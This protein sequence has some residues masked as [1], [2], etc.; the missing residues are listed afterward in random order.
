MTISMYN[1]KSRMECERRNTLNQISIQDKGK[2]YHLSVLAKKA[3]IENNSTMEFLEENMEPGIFYMEQEKVIA[4]KE[5]QIKIKRYLKYLEEAIILD[6]NIDAQMKICGKFVKSHIDLLVF[7]PGL[8]ILEAVNIKLNKPKLS[9]RGRKFSTKPANDVE[10]YSLYNSLLHLDLNYYFSKAYPLK[11]Q[12]EI[13]LMVDKT[14]AV[15]SLHHLTSKKDKKGQLAESYNEKKGDNVIAS[16]TF[17]EELENMLKDIINTQSSF[18]RMENENCE[19]CTYQS[20]CVLESKSQIELEEIKETKIK[21]NNNFNLTKAQ[22]KAINFNN[23]IARINAGAGSGKTTIVSLRVVELIKKGVKP[24]DILLITFTNKGALEM[25]E[26]ISYWLKK[27]DLT[28]VNIDELDIMTFNAWG[29]EVLD[30][31]Y[32]ILGYTDKPKLAYQVDVYDIVIE[33]LEKNHDYTFKAFDCSNPLMNY[34]YSKGIVIRII[35][36]FQYIKAYYI[37]DFETLINSSLVKKNYYMN[38]KK[39]NSLYLP[40]ELEEDL[41]F[42]YSLY[43]DFNAELKKRNLIEYQD[44]INSV[45]ELIDSNTEAI[46]KLQYEHII[47]DEFQDSDFQQL[48]IAQFLSKRDKFKSLMVVG[49]D[50]QSIYGFRNTSQEI[51]LNFHKYFDN[52]VDINII[53]NFRSTKPILDLANKVNDLNINKIEKELISGNNKKGKE[54]LLLKFANKHDEVNYISEEGILKDIDNG[55]NPENIAFLARTQSELNNMYTKLMELNIPAKI[56]MNVPLIDNM[57]FHLL[58]DLADYINNNSIVTEHNEGL[59]K[60]LYIYQKDFKNLSIEAMHEFLKQSINLIELE[61]LDGGFS[62]IRKD[63]KLVGRPKDRENTRKYNLFFHMASLIDDEQI[64]VLLKEIKEDKPKYFKDLSSYLKK[65]I[66]YK[67]IQSIEIEEKQ[68]KAVTLSTIH[69]SKGREWDK[70]YVSLS[71]FKNDKD[72][73]IEEERRLIFV[74]LTRAKKELVISSLKHNAY[75]KEIEDLDTKTLYV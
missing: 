13:K 16:N 17:S 65:V 6:K 34:F 3:I 31:Y 23:G 41:K 42:I 21:A 54:P 37:Q 62:P 12:A 29:G 51:I 4:L 50:S 61:I 14:I 36:L 1:L 47:I 30:R 55:I 32:N 15:G 27:K 58:V 2:Y 20:I 73:D 75:A 19:N 59:L 74:G 66:L 26:K 24:E 60:F 22:S 71:K 38:N 63:G 44:Q 57:H 10:L 56:D 33:L 5:L 72:I 40:K 11:S 46:K 67:D 45:L 64:K 69:S 25:K 18:E 49:D 43:R 53:E 68:Y 9:Y 48:K 7:H 52:V 39:T 35:E 28:N 70:V 8:N